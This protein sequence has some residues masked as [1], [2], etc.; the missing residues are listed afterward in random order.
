MNSGVVFGS[1]TL[2]TNEVTVVDYGLGNLRSIA[3]ALMAVGASYRFVKGVNEVAT[4]PK[5]LLPGVGAYR[6]G[7]QNLVQSGFAEAIRESAAKGNFVLGICL[8]M[9]LLMDEGD[10]GGR[11]TG[12]GLL[13]GKVKKFET[14]GDLRIP[15]MG[16][17]EVRFAHPSPL[18]EGIPD[19]SDFYFVHSYHATV[20]DDKNILATTLH[21]APF[22]SVI[23]RDN[24]FGTQFHPE[25]SQSQGLKLL[26]NFCEL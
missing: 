5:L 2:S 23:G 12:L 6:V 22:A 9:Q 13:P 1:L 18:F 8:G 11:S 15:H 25:K 21:G 10:E 7:M 16:F 24:V 17:N 19:C 26:K 20:A 14:V 4:A 3:N